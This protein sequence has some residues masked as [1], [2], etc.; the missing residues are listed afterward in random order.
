MRKTAFA[1]AAALAVAAGALTGCQAV[2]RPEALT[3]A[4]TATSID[5]APVLGPIAQMAT[6][7]ASAA[8]LPGDGKVSVVTP[9]GSETVDLTPMRGNEVES[10]PAKADKLIAANVNSLAAV[11]ARSAAVKAGLDV[12][13]V[14][15]RALEQTP[16]GGHVILESSGFSTEDP[17][18]LNKAGNWMLKPDAFV[19][20]VD[21]NDLPHADGKHITFFGLGYPNPASAQEQASPAVRKA[22]TRI[23]L[24][25][26]TK[27]RA[28]SC[29]VIPGPAGQAPAVSKNKA[30]PVVLDRIATRCVGQTSIDASVAFGG[31]S[32]VIL[33]AADQ[34]LA[35]IAHSL[36]R[37]PAGSKVEAVGHS[38]LLVGEAPGQFTWLELARAQ[39]VL[40]R[41]VVLGAPVG[42]IGTASA[43]GQI[44]NNL[45]GG[46]YD[47]ALAAKN[48]TVTLAIGE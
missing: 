40:S 8:L 1:A 48:R 14:L 11:L 46:V 35:P 36:A 10:V 33:A 2:P 45:P 6:D 19:A 20:T 37:C 34:V 47:E 31:N 18:D 17:I 24:G 5:P 39:A 4:A 30:T 21:P 15:D 27:M 26:C 29:D 23:M 28:A 12:L 38:A 42:S 9:E 13:G 43:G 41:L 32:A 22:L 44:V 7:H 25:L 3:I 16:A